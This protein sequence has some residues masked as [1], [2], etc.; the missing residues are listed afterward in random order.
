MSGRRTPFAL[1]Q[2]LKKMARENSLENCSAD[3][4]WLLERYVARW[5]R[6]SELGKSLIAAHADL[7]FEQM[8]DTTIELLNAGFLK[9]TADH[10]GFTG[11]ETRFP[12]EPPL[13]HIRRSL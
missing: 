8:M 6:E 3:A 5:L 7:N 10:R 13:A 1:G 11:I 4:G 12:P 2:S 9:I